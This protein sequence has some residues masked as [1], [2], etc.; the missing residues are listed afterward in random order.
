MVSANKPQPLIIYATTSDFARE[1]I[2]NEITDYAIKVQTGVVDEPSF[3]PV[4]YMADREDDWTS[5]ATWAKA[6]PNMGVS[7]SEDDLARE[8][9]I[10]QEIPTKENEFKRLHLNIRTEQS[11]RLVTMAS[12]DA[13]RVD[14]LPDLVG[15]RCWCGLD[16]AAVGDF[17]AFVAVFAWQGKY[18]LKPMFWLPKAATRKRR[19]AMGATFEVWERTG[20]VRFTHGNEVDYSAIESDIAAF[21]KQY[22]VEE[23]AAD[24][25]FQGAQLCQNLGERHGIAIVEHGQGFLS[26]A[27]PTKQFLEAVSGGQVIHDGDPVLRW[28]VSNLTGKQDEAGNWKPDK[29][30]SAEKIDGVVATIMGLGRAIANAGVSVYEGRGIRSV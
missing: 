8:C 1:S 13:C 24:R 15:Q 25:L 21:A 27:L 11:E 18:V 2:C 14:K 23:V 26:M 7:V 12:W 22:A 6:N 17:T 5:P 9:K 10:A 19:D 30:R 28:M 4:L 16:L 20:A 29:K 3:L